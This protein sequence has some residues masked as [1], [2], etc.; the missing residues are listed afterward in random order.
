MML[1]E[2][3]AM[4][5]LVLA[6]DEAILLHMRR[7]RSAGV[8]LLMTLFTRLG[9]AV[10]WVFVALVL[11]ACGGTAALTG[12]RLGVA[13]GAAALVSQVLK[14]LWRRA[15]PTSG[16]VGFTALA[17]NPDAFSFPSGH[18]AAAFAVAL[19]MAGLVPG[20]P[21]FVVLAIAIG[22]SRVYLGAHY[23]LDVAIGACIGLLCGG[24]TRMVL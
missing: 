7:W 6:L 11:I 9:D 13:A 23:P 24:L 17:E 15:R 16:I 12:L 5:R 2:G 21:A 1:S 8:T 14:R 4:V 19:A 18:A 10:S 20:G 22:L 3:G